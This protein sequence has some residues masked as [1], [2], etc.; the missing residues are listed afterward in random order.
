M[1]N[2]EVEETFSKITFGEPESM[3]YWGF[4]DGVEERTVF[5][6]YG[7]TLGNSV[8]SQ[9]G[10][11]WKAETITVDDERFSM[12]GNTFEWDDGSDSKESN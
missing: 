1:D 4:T 12:E 3:M 2:K 7:L 5:T 9:D 8:I 6:D 10:T 11:I